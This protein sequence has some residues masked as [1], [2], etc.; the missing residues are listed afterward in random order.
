M[1]TQE[2]FIEVLQALKSCISVPKTPEETARLLV[3][4]D[5]IIDFVADMELSQTAQG[6]PEPEEIVIEDEPVPRMTSDQVLATIRNYKAIQGT[7]GNWD[8][9][10]YM[11]GMYNGIEICL[12]LLESRAPHFKNAPDHWRGE[13]TIERP[14]LAPT[15]PLIGTNGPNP[16]SSPNGPNPY[17]V[18]WG[19]NT[20]DSVSGTGVGTGAP[21]PGDF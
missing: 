8:Y 1:T 19:V 20:I 9:G 2:K 12:S 4:V 18:V 11:H 17:S 10:P 6:E 3:A 15:R 5:E 14:V 16:Y 21:N 7:E 13:R